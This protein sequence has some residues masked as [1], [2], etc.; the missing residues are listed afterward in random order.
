MSDK[1]TKMFQAVFENSPV[2]LILVN[3]D[4]SIRDANAYMF[5][6]FNLGQ[7]AIRGQRFGNLFNCSAVSGSG[8][9]CGDC[10]AC[11]KCRL[12]VGMSSVLCSGISIPDTIM[13]HKFIIDGQEQ[14][15]W[16]KVSA[17][18][19]DNEGD[20]FA[21]LSF[22]DITIQKEYE[23]LLNYRLSLDMATGTINKY[24]LMGTLRRMTAAGKEFTVALI[25]FDNF[26]SI[27]DNHGHITGDKIISHFCAAALANTRKQDI[28][29]RFGGEE[30]MIVFQGAGSGM[31]IKALERIS[32][33][34]QETCLRS[35][36]IKPT[37]SAGLAEFNPFSQDE[38]DVDS[39]VGEADSNLYLSKK[40]GKNMITSRGLTMFFE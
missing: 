22:A 3:R 40:R 16:F 29:G 14:K 30:F 19:I 27:N 33:S 37:F 8:I 2:G 15:K 20:F 32:K 10:D 35:V 24:A 39:L 36:G 34:F 17:S 28:V 38:T 31:L 12:R 4:T 5:N 23:E 7:T 9:T 21:I 26:K 25:D 13:D 18:R 11:G 6:M 1:S